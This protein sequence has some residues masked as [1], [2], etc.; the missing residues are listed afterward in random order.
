[1]KIIYHIKNQ[2]NIILTDIVRM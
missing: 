2:S 1:M